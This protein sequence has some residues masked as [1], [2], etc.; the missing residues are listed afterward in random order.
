MVP[1][2]TAVTRAQIQSHL[3][4]G[5]LLWSQVTRVLD[6]SQ[7]LSASVAASSP[8]PSTDSHASTGPNVRAFDC[9]ECRPQQQHLPSLPVPSALKLQLLQVRTSFQK[10]RRGPSINVSID[11]HL[12]ETTHVLLYTI[13][14]QARVSISQRQMRHHWHPS[15]PATQAYKTCPRWDKRAV[16]TQIFSI[17]PTIDLPT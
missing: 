7:R 16:N 11:P 8:T 1:G 3:D 14:P 4:A 12:L 13:C 6:L 10:S 9:P 2:N 5:V 15:F 17:N